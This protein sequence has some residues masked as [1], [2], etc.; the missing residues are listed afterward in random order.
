[1]TAVLE[2]PPRQAT[3]TGGVPARRAV[4]R[5]AWRLFCRE[6]QQQLL[7]L[8]MLTVA[9][10]AMIW[11]VGVASGTPPPGTATYGTASAAIDLPGGAHLAAEIAA[12]QQKY[13]PADVIENQAL[14]T[15]STQSVQLRAQDPAGRFGAPLLALVSG[16]YPDGPGQ[17]A[18]TSQVASLYNVKAGGTWPA[19]GRAWHVTG[20]VENPTD[21]NDEFALVVPGQV[22]APTQVTILLNEPA[23]ASREQHLYGPGQAPPP[24]FT[25]LPGDATVSLASQ[26]SSKGVVGPA[27]IVLAIAVL[28]LVFIGLVSVAGFT[29]I[30]QRRLRALGMLS[31]L[32]AT[33]RNVRLVMTANGAVVGVAAA[34]TGAAAGFAAWFAYLPALERDT[35]HRIDPL[36]LP[37]WAIAVG[38]V[39]AIGTSVLAAR[40][41]A[42]AMA[43]VPVVQALSGRPPEPKAVH[44]SAPPG[45][46]LLAAG[47]LCLL[48][49]GGWS[50]NSGS[51][52]LLLLGGLVATV[53]GMFLLA[54]VCVAALSKFAGPRAP[55]AVRIALRDLVR[56]RARSGA[57]LA[58]VSF[59]V[60]LA[61]LI[62]IVASVRFGNVLDYTG[63]NLTASQLI[64]YSQ[65]QGPDAGPG[66]GLDQ[67]QIAALQAKVDGFAR[68]LDSR[69]VLTLDTVNATLEQQGRQNNNF[70]GTLYVATPRLLAAYGI[71]DVNPG[72]DI[73][74]MRPGLDAVPRMQL[75]YG[76]LGSPKANPKAADNPVIDEV[77]GLPSG[78][79][80]P[81]TLITE[82]AI[83]QYG[84]HET[85]Q[86]WFIETRKPLTTEQIGAA[87][88]L[89]AAAGV[90]AETKS[91]EL[92]LGEIADGATVLGLVIALGVLVMSVGLVR[93]ETA[94]E[95][96]TLTA[97]G[98]SSRV[99]RTLTGATAGAIGLLGAVLG[100]AVAAI[101]GVAWARSSLS[102]TFGNIPAADLIAILVGLPV[103]AA[104][105]GW[106]L[107]GRQPAAI[108]RQPL[109]LG[110][111]SATQGRQADEPWRPCAP[112]SPPRRGPR[113]GAG[114]R[115]G[116]SRCRPRS[117]S[118]WPGQAVARRRRPAGPCR[119]P[120]PRPARPGSPTASRA[121]C[122]RW[123]RRSAPAP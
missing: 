19:D 65:E 26:A 69:Y 62:A 39:L 63:Q 44:R 68:S 18:L 54:P 71:K 60:F 34:L 118:G 99:R 27:T 6:W 20:I 38:I 102:T 35:A 123:P 77:S 11:G 94:G 96:R 5:W 50:A 15:G 75:L 29:V 24:A 73:L 111:K 47:L 13:G 3:A 30:A 57:A 2:G 121:R 92:G 110:I 81:N 43:R 108:S 28:G 85:V 98:A 37:W 12:I 116:P 53:T 76:D 8:G 117:R 79:S 120:R 14:S 42:R 23:A 80:A 56:Y 113:T 22:T 78:T 67:A 101:A 119:G 59:A 100:T 61:V 91:G 17:V 9:V 112:G 36:N 51:A 31:A 64:V 84:L 49:S 74:T 103:V 58:A 88:Q 66:Q 95:L 83:S 55:V 32:G 107:A 72:A 45:L 33:E 7:V 106:L 114:P 52:A 21:L 10:A 41:P 16:R 1:M 105:G 122:P 40:R 104:V 48:F 46:I 4:V 89:A 93:S 25:G 87:R 97:A 115:P 90:S 109:E 70:S 86:G 82:H